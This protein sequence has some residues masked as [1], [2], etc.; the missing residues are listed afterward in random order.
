MVI[1]NIHCQAHVICINTVY[2]LCAV[3][4]CEKKQKCVAVWAAGD[5]LS[6]VSILQSG[7]GPGLLCACAQSN[8]TL[9]P[10]CNQRLTCGKK[11]GE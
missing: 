5:A 7:L 2:T 1:Q 4:P 10:G 3:L 6:F 9:K 8:S 11:N